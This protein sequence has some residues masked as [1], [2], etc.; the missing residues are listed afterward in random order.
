MAGFLPRIGKFLLDFFILIPMSMFD[1][2]Q[3][4][5]DSGCY[6]RHMDPELQDVLLYIFGE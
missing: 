1:N 4:E 6:R 2:A 3:S 5:P